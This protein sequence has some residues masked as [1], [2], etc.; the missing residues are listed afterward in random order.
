[1]K[2]IKSLLLIPFVAVV[3]FLSLTPFTGCKKTV[4]VHDTTTVVIHDT[5]VVKDTLY[6]ITSGLVAWYN[7][8]GGTLKDSS[9]FNNHIVFNNATATTDRF[10]RTGNAY[11]FNGSSSYMQVSNSNSLNPNSITLF[12]IIKVN[13]FYAGP[14]NGNQIFQ[15]AYTDDVNGYYGLRFN[16]Y[17][18]CSA[19]SDS[20]REFF[21]GQ[22]GDNYP[23]GSASQVGAD[24][25]FVKKGVWYT[26][27]Y[28]YDGM[29]SRIYING[30]LKNV[31]QKVIPFTPN[32][33]NLFIGKQENPSY[34]YWFNG[35]IDEI[36][37]YN[38]ALSQPAVTL[39]NKLTN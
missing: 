21:G 11:L 17:N 3:I 19:G 23:Q 36:R 4:T 5:T 16:S 39:L 26:I 12:A 33:N 35:V 6:D 28:T 1:M 27:A 29:A 34:P 20:T 38:R 15:K 25:V 9:G 13:G 8:N 31:Q 2:F 14:C 10:G 30:V 37:I 24:T 7:F 18:S 32:S 22:F